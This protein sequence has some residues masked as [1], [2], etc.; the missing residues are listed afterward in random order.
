MRK[1]KLTL[2]SKALVSLTILTCSTLWDAIYGFGNL[3]TEVVKYQTINFI[4]SAIALITFSKLIQVVLKGTNIA[5]LTYVISFYYIA[6]ECLYVYN[7]IKYWNDWDSWCNR[8]YDYR[9][10]IPAIMILLV[11]ISIAKDIFFKNIKVW[12]RKMLTL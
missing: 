1:Y 9:I 3:P 7:Y 10:L 5:Y 12:L 6:H 2:K 4:A 11:I 8:F